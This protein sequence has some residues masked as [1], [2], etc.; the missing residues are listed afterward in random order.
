MKESQL[1]HGDGLS[2]EIWHWASNVLLPNCAHQINVILL[3]S[4]STHGTTEG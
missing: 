2:P 3:F 1:F 4:L